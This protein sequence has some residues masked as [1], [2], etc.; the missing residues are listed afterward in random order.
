M[1]FSSVET[2]TRTFPGSSTPFQAPSSSG[3]PHR[4]VPWKGRFAP[5][6][7]LERADEKDGADCSAFLRSVYAGHHAVARAPAHDTS[8]ATR[9]KFRV[10]EQP[11]SSA[12]ETDEAHPGSSA[13]SV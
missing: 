5:I 3:R 6:P 11:P 10:R 12:K 9:R 1:P 4:A 2:E 8:S 13:I 7:A